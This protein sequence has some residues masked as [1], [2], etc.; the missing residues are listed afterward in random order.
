MVEGQEGIEHGGHVGQSHLDSGQGAMPDLLE[1]TDGGE[2]REGGLNEHALV[3]LPAA[4]ELEVGRVAV[5]GMKAL[6]RE[7]D[8]LVR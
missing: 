1:S 4:T 8:A 7:H 5:G 2:E 3:P 6:V